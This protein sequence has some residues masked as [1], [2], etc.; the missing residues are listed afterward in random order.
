MYECMYV[1]R[2]NRSHTSNTLCHVIVSGSISKRA[3]LP[4]S[5]VW[6]NSIMILSNVEV[7]G[8]V[9]SLLPSGVSSLG[10]VLVMPSFAKR[11]NMTGA[12]FLDPSF[13]GGHKRLNREASFCWLS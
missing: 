5:E 9:E 11:F 8:V 3:N 7:L 2:K 4:C 6:H 12:N 13:S 10:S 1:P